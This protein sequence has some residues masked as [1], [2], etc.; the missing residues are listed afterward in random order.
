MAKQAR[1]TRRTFSLSQ[2]AVRYLESVRKGKQA[3]S[4]SSVLE[5]LI[6]KRR[7]AEEMDRISASITGYYDS[8]TDDQAAQD[9]AWGQFSESQFPT[10]E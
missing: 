6:R 1:K 7:E 2:E 3:R 10:E 9:R 4:I 5:D 8:L